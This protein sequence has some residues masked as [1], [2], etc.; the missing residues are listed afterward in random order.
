MP[1]NNFT[2]LLLLLVFSTG[3]VFSQTKTQTEQLKT[4]YTRRVAMERATAE[5][6][7]V[8][9][10]NK[11]WPMTLK[12]RNN[13]Y[14][15][16][17]NV[18]QR[19]Y[20]VYL[21]TDNN[22]RAAATIGTNQLWPGGSL[23]LTLS[24]SSSIMKNK[25]AVW[26]GGRVRPT[27]QELTGRVNNKDGGANS[28]HST[29]VAGTIMAKGINPLA[30]GMVY[31]LQELIAYDFNDHMSEMLFEAPALLI[32]NH[33]YGEIAGWF[34]NENVSPSRW[35]FRG[36]AGENEDFKFGHYSDDAQSW[37]EMAFNAPDY[38]I[39][40]SAGNNRD[41]NGPAV[42]QPYYRYDASNVMGPAG[43][44]PAGI[45]SNDGY[46]I[47]STYGTAK[48]ILT[49]G[50]VDPLPSGYS[51]PTDVVLAEFSS[52]GPTDD[53][54]IKPDVV[55]NG[56]DVLSSVA[57]SDNAYATFSGTSMATP[58]ASGSLGLLQE[59]Y[60]QLNGSTFMRSATLKALVIHTA[61]E[62]GPANGPDYKHGWGL[63]NMVK[64]AEV[65][66]G[67]NL[68]NQTHRIQQLKLTN[69]AP[70]FLVTLIASGKGPLVATICW[71][72]PKGAVSTT[73]LLNN[74]DIKLVNDLDLRIKKGAT[75]FM[76]WI[77]NPASRDAAAT[78]GDNI[79]DNV[80]KIEIPDAIPG[81]QY[82]IEVTRKGTLT[83]NE[84]AFSL[85][86]SGIGGTAYC[87]SAP[88]SAAPGRID[89]VSFGGIEKQNA[90]DC[91]GYRD[92]TSLVA[93]IEPGS[94]VPLYV[95]VGSCDASTAVKSVKAF[96][97]FNGDGTFGAGEMVGEAASLATN[98][99][100]TLNVAIPGNVII[101]NT[102]IMRIIA[103][104]TS[105]LAD[106]SPCGTYNLGE[107]QDYRVKFVAPANDLGITAIAGP[108][109]TRCANPVEYV[110]VRIKNYGTSDKTNIALTGTVKDGGTTVQT[111]SATFPGKVPALG[112][113]TYTFST[114]FA[115]QAGITYTINCKTLLGN[116]Q[117]TTNDEK[118]A[119]LVV[120]ANGATP[121]GEAEIC[122]T[123]V[124]FKASTGNTI[125]YWYDS[126]TATTPIAAGNVTSS[127]VITAD[128]KYYLATNLSDWG[129][130]AATRT[131]LTTSGAFSTY[132]NTFITMKAGAPLTIETA[133]LYIASGS[134][135]GKAE[136]ILGRNFSFSGSSYS[137]TRI[138]STVIDIYPTDQNEG[139][140]FYLGL[141]IPAAGDYGLII[142]QASG[143]VQTATFF[144]NT[145]IPTNPYTA[146][147]G[148]NGVF[149][150]TGNYKKLIANN[151][152]WMNFYYV[153]YDL[154]VRQ[155]G[156]ANT[157]RTAVTAG[158]A[159]VPVITLNGNVLNS[160]IA[161]GNQW[162]L[163]GNP[164][165]GA[166]N[167][168]YSPTASGNYKVVV[169]DAFNCST[170]SNV[171]PYAVTSVPNVDPAE[172]GL[173]VYPNPSD[174]EF[175]TEF[176]VRTKATLSV[177]IVNA[178][179]QKVYE[180][181]YPDFV[182][183]FNK[184]IEARNLASGVYLLRIQHDNKSYLK[185]L[186]VR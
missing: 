41:V 40:K 183:K 119:T 74:P 24:G 64:A 113:V 149:Q 91:N 129:A 27:H 70:T 136:V 180:N 49:I 165:V 56:V 84:Q 1:R 12:G 53:G 128:K 181:I 5:R 161:S 37:D 102:T 139:A 111:L 166:V 115:T 124:L 99:N 76:P 116:D 42:G 126:Q 18:D 133:R 32:S 23:G 138:A 153:F 2:L 174:G 107:T 38:L 170:E 29:H 103:Q 178:V 177:S 8:L 179:G 54:R 109:G 150:V 11:N 81:A 98:G 87:S 47:I 43:N 117:V 131:S 52:W 134:T 22:I 61:S 143:Q 89:S 45:S 156:C 182:G 140:V 104:H 97:D 151:T 154:R 130:G 25:L 121:S 132:N 93:E 17:V 118:T 77:L 85:V 68:A 160:S 159:P 110:T 152:D 123:S 20:P 172:I 167:Q 7:Q 71:T 108:V 122:N 158:T 4:D 28:D 75:T 101:G 80:E 31:D 186:F 163:E 92:Y 155:A 44:R 19:G 162:Y 34:E 15:L 72:D 83:N 144:S 51:K 66:K 184:T 10:K 57:T 78:T 35:E 141:P 145:N 112:E 135:S 67:N 105:N 137:F 21:I 33:S 3:T 16:L 157:T 127:N 146:G 65:I 164:I 58:N 73:N 79:R 147:L 125:N 62:A 171:I 14:A 106:I 176:T 173:K 90:F 168:S 114:F 36:A 148:V 48:N 69:A 55:A 120:S 46:D 9:A 39:V 59:Y 13:S 100:T 6:L 26:D 82:T 175:I 185:K 142:S 50:A 94:T 88:V 86:L 63:I 30:K 95:E 96:I 169:K 60:A